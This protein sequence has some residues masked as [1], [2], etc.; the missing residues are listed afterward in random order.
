M[1]VFSRSD[2]AEPE[3][4]GIIHLRRTLECFG[5]LLLPGAEAVILSDLLN[6]FRAFQ[7][8]CDHWNLLGVPWQSQLPN[9][10]IKY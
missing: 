3:G 4:K 1:W 7:G 10:T 2:A 5:F 9:R 6:V 8:V